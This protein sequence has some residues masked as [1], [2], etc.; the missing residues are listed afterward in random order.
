MHCRSAVLMVCGLTSLAGVKRWRRGA[1]NGF[2][3]V[4]ASHRAAGW[5]RRVGAVTLS[6]VGGGVGCGPSL[7]VLQLW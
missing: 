5:C 6:V 2:V 1:V 7:W 3:C 4:N